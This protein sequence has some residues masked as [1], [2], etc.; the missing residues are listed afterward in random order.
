MSLDKSN[1]LALRD[2]FTAN[3]W[4]TLAAAICVFFS[5]SSRVRSLTFLSR[6]V[7]ALEVEL[8]PLQVGDQ[9][10]ALDEAAAWMARRRM[11]S[12]R[13]LEKQCRSWRFSR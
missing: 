4:S 6:L 5:S 2:F 1:G 10:H 11:R 7:V 8:C 12:V 13:S 9:G 3:V